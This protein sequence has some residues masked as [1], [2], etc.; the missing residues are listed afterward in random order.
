MR[1][2]RWLVLFSV[3]V[4]TQ[5]HSPRNRSAKCFDNVLM[6]EFVHGEDEVA[7]GAVDE[8]KNEPQRWSVPRYAESRC[9]TGMYLLCVLI[10]WQ[11]QSIGR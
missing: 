10:F 2:T 5:R 9:Y 4:A 11:L 8:V 7:G 3:Q 6:V 1:G